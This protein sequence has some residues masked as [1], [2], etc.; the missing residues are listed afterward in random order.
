[1]IE[2]F[3]FGVL[4]LSSV[5]SE[6][7]I[8]TFEN[9]ETDLLKQGS[10]YLFTPQRIY[11]KGHNSLND[12]HEYNILNQNPIIPLE[13]QNIDRVV[14]YDSYAQ[15]SNSH[16]YENLGPNKNEYLPYSHPDGPLAHTQIISDNIH[17][18]EVTKKI[19]SMNLDQPYYRIPPKNS[20]QYYNHVLNGHERPKT[21]E[22]LALKNLCVDCSHYH[23][24]E[25]SH[26]PTL[27]QHEKS[28]LNEQLTK[29]IYNPYLI[30]NSENNHGYPHES[31]TDAE[32][33][34][35]RLLDKVN[36]IYYHGK[37]I[38][39][40]KPSQKN[41]NHY[42]DKPEPNHE[43]Y[44]GNKNDASDRYTPNVE[45]LVYPRSKYEYE[46][47]N[48]TNNDTKTN[49][50]I[51]FNPYFDF[52][53]D[54]KTVN[55]DHNS[56]SGDLTAT[57]L[58]NLLYSKNKYPSSY[59]NA[60]TNDLYN[61]EPKHFYNNYTHE[62]YAPHNYRQ[63]NNE[64]EDIIRMQYPK[65][66]YNQYNVHSNSLYHNGYKNAYHGANVNNTPNRHFKDIVEEV[67]RILSSRKK[68]VPY[69]NAYYKDNHEHITDVHELG[70]KK[71]LE[72]YVNDYA[73]ER[74]ID[75]KNIN[76]AYG[77]LD[78]HQHYKHFKDVVEEAKK[79]LEPKNKYDAYANVH[80]SDFDHSR[81]RERHYGKLTH[82]FDRTSVGVLHPYKVRPN[83]YI[84]PEYR[85]YQSQY[86]NPP[87]NFNH[88]GNLA[89]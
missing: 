40:T 37:D 44:Y 65:N 59:F 87:R 3:I 17:G 35:K 1:M 74:F 86:N 88:H 84:L 25:Y 64:V 6:K 46:N 32:S 22:E 7:V 81:P 31:Y 68:H 53:P 42:Y 27:Y 57:V 26:N 30:H 19:P 41:T 18:L 79:L 48:T 71:H 21:Y 4:A 62:N 5:S 29:D 80:V 55:R 56:Y 72:P 8:E 9:E 10:N 45:A 12:G 73:G 54:A 23:G 38:Q 34:K 15:H 76:N 2:V 36:Y 52:A 11:F 78:M 28:A 60:H 61:S 69:I 70:P 47:I 75:P 89:Y 43:N 63:M 33:E 14:K 49:Q 51:Y 16:G 83:H 66:N 20:I 39:Y 58:K 82:P 50:N 13:Q 24:N 67:N 85:R 77:Q